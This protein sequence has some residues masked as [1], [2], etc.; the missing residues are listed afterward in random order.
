MRKTL[1]D[2]L[3]RLLEAGLVTEKYIEDGTKDVQQLSYNSGENQENGLFICK[4][5]AF[6]EAYLQAAIKKGAI[7]YISETVYPDVDAA[8]VIV[9]DIRETMAVLANMFYEEAWKAFDLLGITGTKGKT[10]TAFLLKRILD[11]ASDK[12]TGVL[13]SVTNYVGGEREVSHLTTPETLDLHRYFVEARENGLS[14]LTMEVS[15]QALKY[16]RVG[17]ITFSVAAFLNI[18][19]D[20]ISP[21]EHKDFEDYFASK[22][23]IFEN[24]QVACVN[25]D[26]DHAERI[27]E[28]AKQAKRTVTFGQTAEADV[29]AYDIKS[30]MTGTTFSVR[31]DRFEE[32]FRLNM[33][34]L[35]NVENALCAIA[36]AY[37][38]GIPGSVIRS[39]LEKAHVHGR[40]ECFQGVNAKGKSIDVIVDFA[41]NRMSFETLFRDAA[42]RYKGKRI[43]IVFGSVGEKAFDRRRDLAEVSGRYA[44]RI[45][46]TEDDPGKED[47]TSIC[48][49]MASFIPERKEAVT[50][51][52]DR[53]KACI[54]ALDGAMDGDLVILA[55]R[56][57]EPEQ[58]RKDGYVAVRTDVEIVEDYFAQNAEK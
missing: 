28:A 54:M 37:I 42:K 10:T 17:G 41:H 21:R 50:I 48:R 36:V 26:A 30:D 20:H 8:Y 27:L 35:F 23:K 51:E 32:T 7:C 46:L 44:D 39:G 49:E 5:E 55:G 47:V 22:L 52:V 16:A 53:E 15:S 56:G 25:L 14:R 57:R 3:S 2:C 11:E 58:K 18:G 43:S 40:M 33:P 45:I 1:D 31:T 13:S 38:L 12:E 6:K 24:C 4:G 34:G 19:T 9:T 29:Y